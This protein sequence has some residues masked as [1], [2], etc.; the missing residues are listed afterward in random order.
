MK[1]RTRS[2][3][4]SLSVMPRK[5]APAELPHGSLARRADCLAATPTA[6]RWRDVALTP[7]TRGRRASGRLAEGPGAL[8]EPLP[9]SDVIS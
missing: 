7:S 8:V 3:S 6:S 9:T 4:R 2:R 5:S 1:A